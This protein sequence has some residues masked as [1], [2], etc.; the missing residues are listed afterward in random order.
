MTAHEHHLPFWR[1]YIFS[2]DHKVIGIQFL[3]TSLL[4]FV[5]GG[6][7]AMA[8]RWQLA[9]PKREEIPVVGKMLFGEGG[10]VTPEDYTM[11]FTMHGS[12]MIFFVIIPILVGAF[13]NYLIPLQIGAPDMAFPK[14]NMLSYWMVVPSLTIMC[15]GF[16]VEGGAAAAGWTAY[17]P[18][19]ALKG[20]QPQEAGQ[21]CW[22]ISVIILGF[23]SIIGSLNYITTIVNMRAPGMSFFRMPLTV[24][25]LFITAVLVLLATPVLASAMVMLLLDKTLQTS[26]FIPAGAVV[27]D[28]LENVPNAGG[29][30]PLLWQHLFWFYSHPAVY[31]MIL[32]GMGMVSDIIAVFARKPIFGYKPMVYSIGGIAGLGFIVWAHHMFQAGMNPTLAIAFTA[33]TMMIALPSAVKIFNW[34]G[35]LWGGNIR[36]TV[37]M[38][39]ALAF[40]SMF[41]IGGLSGIFMAS[42]PVDI[43][44]HDTYFIVGHIHYV[45]FG[46]SVFGIFA[47]IYMW[48]PKMFGKKMNH[49]LGVMH[50]AYTFVFM[51]LTFFLMHVVG[52]GGHPRRI[53]TILKDGFEGFDHL[54]PTNVFM[55]ISAFA[56]GIGQIPF[57]IN[58]FASLIGVRRPGL[59]KIALVVSVVPMLALFW[60]MTDISYDDKPLELGPLTKIIATI[61]TLACC[62]PILRAKPKESTFGDPAGDNPWEATTL[63]WT[64]PSPPGHGN[65]ATTPE[66]HCGPHEYSVPGA[67]EDWVP[68]TRELPAAGAATP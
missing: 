57:V 31:I 49:A 59:L 11:L 48:Y 4:M 21:I 15:T 5:V 41:V 46:G 52:I 19:S 9:W 28:M 62:I 43:H 25:S 63:E 42:T 16:F 8:V 3:F 32:P 35:T 7:L 61:F 50:F 33:S 40:V 37:P 55:T 20:A 22:I 67:D 36:L 18:L 45:L 47:G 17:P 60:G 44:I 13:G 12:I 24:W 6:L 66:V 34:L 51:N 29:G 23:S 38:L 14:L 1:K 64:A 53:A 2:T 65:F 30:Q 10:F 54:Q 56:L 27:S 58:F 39:N 26:F 68:Q